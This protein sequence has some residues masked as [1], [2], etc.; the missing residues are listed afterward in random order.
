MRLDENSACDGWSLRDILNLFLCWIWLS[1]Q[2]LF[3]LFCVLKPTEE[4]RSSFCFKF[5]LLISRIYKVYGCNISPMLWYLLL[6]IWYVGW[7]WKISLSLSLSLFMVVKLQ[8]KN[9][10]QR[11][12]TRVDIDEAIIYIKPEDEIFHKVPILWYLDLDHLTL[13]PDCFPKCI[14]AQLMVLQFSFA[15]ATCYNSWG[16]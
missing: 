2:N 11:K 4:L 8:H 9:A 12:G 14:S 6:V 7:L 13:F 5:F 10:G 1:L 15:H 16:K 3:F